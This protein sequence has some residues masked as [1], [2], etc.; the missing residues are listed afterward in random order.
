MSS[1]R[2]VFAS[3]ARGRRRVGTTSTPAWTRSERAKLATA[4][5][6]SRRVSQRTSIS[7]SSIAAYTEMPNRPHC[8]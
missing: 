3:A 4:A 2:S 8:G 6:R 5:R 1:S 7:W